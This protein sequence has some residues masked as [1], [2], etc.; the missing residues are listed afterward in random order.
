MVCNIQTATLQSSEYVFSI[1]QKE[2]THTHKIKLNHSIICFPTFTV[3]FQSQF[4]WYRSL[5]IYSRCFLSRTVSNHR[6]QNAQIIGTRIFYCC[7][8]LC[9]G[10]FRILKGDASLFVEFCH[11][12]IENFT[13]MG[14]KPGW[15]HEWFSCQKKITSWNS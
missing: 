2:Y 1:F 9:S 3:F 5:Q 11:F 12:T 14:E 8:G 15:G 10:I 4:T 13:N 7:L 6:H